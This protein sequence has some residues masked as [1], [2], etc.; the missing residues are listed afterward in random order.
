MAVRAASA[1]PAWVSNRRTS[2]PGLGQ[3][4]RD[5]AAHRA[6]ANDGGDGAGR[7]TADGT[8]DIGSRHPRSKKLVTS[9]S[10]A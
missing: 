2:R 7:A 5:T 9:T 4:L 6:A 3:E 10:R 1:A 8:L